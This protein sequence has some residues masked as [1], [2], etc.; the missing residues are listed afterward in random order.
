MLK[1]VLSG[2]SAVLRMESEWVAGE[3]SYNRGVCHVL[4]MA[5]G[6]KRGFVSRWSRTA[7]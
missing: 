6:V 1:K 7:N 2:F 5:V 3:A 4:A